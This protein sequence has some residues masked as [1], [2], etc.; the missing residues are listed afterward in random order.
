M[1]NINRFLFRNGVIASNGD[2]QPVTTLLQSHSGAYTTTRTL[3][4]GSQLLLWER[5]LTR[6]CDSVQVL[7]N[8]KPEY[9]F[10]SKKFMFRL[11]MLSVKSSMWDSLVRILVNDS[12]KKALPVVLEGRKYEEEIAVTTLVSGNLEELGDVEDL[13]EQRIYEIL[14][15]YL[16]FGSYVPPVF[17]IQGKGAHL[18]VVGHG[19]DV[20]NAKYS[21]WVRH[22]KHLEKLKP[23]SVTE[24]LL[25]SDGDHILEGSVTNFF[26]VCVK[27]RNEEGVEIQTAPLQA[28]VLPGVIRQV[29]IDIC[30]RNAIPFKE[31]APSWSQRE[32]WSEAFITSSLRLLQY[33]ETILAPTSWKSLE[34]KT[35][36]GIT[37]EEKLFQES[38]GRITSIIKEEISKYARREACP[39]SSFK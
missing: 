34:S 13:D 6:L 39:I 1:S 9:L 10:G 21:D 22:R 28:G 17:G 12:M 14:N 38:P 19:R 3:D 32:I 30:S 31:V 5:H 23:P 16:H 24:L 11:D 26:V 36:T 20:A 33:V 8:S 35:W 7:I 25:S 2:A 37:W 4:N 27:D 15:V 29:I 18:A